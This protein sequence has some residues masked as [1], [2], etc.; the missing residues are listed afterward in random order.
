[1]GSSEPQDAASPER[2]PLEEIREHL[3]QGAMGDVQELVQDVEPADIAALLSDLGDDEQSA[4]FRA[5]DVE[6]QAE[7]LGELSDEDVRTIAEA[8]P[9]LLQDAV[10]KM[11]P[12]EV[13]DVLEALPER[14]AE[15][16]L[17]QIP[18]EQAATAERLMVYPPDTAGGLMTTEFVLVYGGLTASDAVKVTQQSREAETVAHLFVAD[19]QDRLVGEV[20]LHRLV[21]A[22]PD[23]LVQDLMEELPLVVDPGTDQEELVRAA[24]R[25]DLYTV[26]VAE[27]GRM[28]GVVTVDDILEAA[29]EETDEDMYRLAGT[30]ERDPVHAS[31]LSSTRLRL[32]WLLLSV[33]DGLLI[34][35]LASRFMGLSGPRELWYF[36]PLIPLMGGQVAIQGS[37]IVVRALAL[38]TIRR[39]RIMPFLAK[40]LVIALLLALCC[41]AAAMLLGTAVV[42]VEADVMGAVGLAVAV[43]IVFAGMLGMIFPFG[44]SAVGIDPAVSAGPLITMLN[45]LFCICIYLWLGALLTSG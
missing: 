17:E 9:G 33:L 22:R 43:A 31:V 12:D 11:E 23:R 2:E 26:P 40:Q 39:S 30:G 34:A 10:G 35:F 36:T 37:T 25:Y 13:A 4:L 27:G 3:E 15:A 8:A 28:V 38:G 20:P 21:F 7:V 42:G 14:Q 44:F 18:E 5:L 29:R 32:P 16:L 6:T 45:D 1:L 41:S 24:T 19:E